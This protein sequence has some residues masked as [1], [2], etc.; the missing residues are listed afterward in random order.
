MSFKNRNIILFII[1]IVLIVVCLIFDSFKIENYT[2]FKISD[3]K[4][5][6]NNLINKKREGVKD[7]TIIFSDYSQKL[8]NQK[9]GLNN[10][11]KTMDDIEDKIY[12]LQNP[13][14]KYLGA[15]KK[16]SQYVYNSKHY[17]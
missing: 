14:K 1:L 4:I 13:S 5:D 11:Q 8:L 17:V 9:E 10:L 6:Y 12:T 7:N 16:K 2:D 15:P 3:I